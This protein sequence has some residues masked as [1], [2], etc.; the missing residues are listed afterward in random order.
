MTITNVTADELRQFI[1]RIEQM[2]AEIA[3][4][5]EARKEIYDEAKSRGYDTAVIRKV[6]ALRK[7]KPDTRAEMEAIMAM[8][9]DALGM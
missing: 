9:Q 3:D 5:T 8:Y 1:E 7:L 4:L 2:N 6:I